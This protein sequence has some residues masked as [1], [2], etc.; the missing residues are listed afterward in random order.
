[1]VWPK[2]RGLVREALVDRE[3]VIALLGTVRLHTEYD[4]N[5]LLKARLHSAEWQNSNRPINK[6]SEEF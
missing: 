5:N 2:L 1:V 4:L 3:A 6:Q